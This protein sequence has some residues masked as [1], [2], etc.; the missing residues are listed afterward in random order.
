MA[1]KSSN[2]STLSSNIKEG[3]LNALKELHTA[4]PG[5]IETFDPIKQT[6]SIQPAIR[7]I[8]KTNL[9]KYFIIEVRHSF[10]L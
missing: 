1:D 5:I 2:I 3:I 6:A 8:I 4:G 10:I 7:R 9:S